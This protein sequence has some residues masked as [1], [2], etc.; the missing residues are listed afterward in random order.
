MR[1]QKYRHRISF[2]MQDDDSQDSNTGAVE[3]EWVPAISDDGV[4]LTDVPALVLT[5]PGR[6]FRAADAKQAETSARIETRW[7]PGL[8]PTWRVLWDG[9]VYDITSIEVDVTARREYR[10][11]CKDG[12]N[13][14]A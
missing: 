10:L 7:F 6:E 14:G 8:A 12:V 11:A 3:L 5:G 4:T 2:E 1:T 9:K 13:D